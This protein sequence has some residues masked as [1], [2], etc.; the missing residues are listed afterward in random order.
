[1]LQKYFNP[2]KANFAPKTAFYFF[3]IVPIITS[4]S[5]FVKLFR[6]FA[7]FPTDFAARKKCQFPLIQRDLGL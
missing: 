2:N 7:H 5:P 6:T 3:R 1:M 4:K